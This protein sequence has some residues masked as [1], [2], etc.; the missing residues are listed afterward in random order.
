MMGKQH[1]SED[2]V[3]HTGMEQKAREFNEQGSEV[4]TTA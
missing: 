2:E 3:L 1:I 4:Y